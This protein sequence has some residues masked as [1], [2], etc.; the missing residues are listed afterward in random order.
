MSKEQSEFSNSITRTMRYLFI[1]PHVRHCA[2]VN[3]TSEVLQVKRDV[4]RNLTST[5]KGQ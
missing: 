5:G 3:Y 1:T 4:Q 2:G